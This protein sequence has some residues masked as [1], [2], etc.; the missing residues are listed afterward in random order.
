[1]KTATRAAMRAVVFE[2]FGGPEVLA[3]C[4][5][6]RPQPGPQELLVRVQAAALNRADTLQRAGVYAPPP[7]QVD[8]PGV[9]I[10]GEVAAWGSEV[11]GF[12]EGDR[13]FGITAGGGYAE[14]CAID[15]GMAIP[16]PEGWSWTV[17]AAVP[18]VFITADLTLFEMGHLRAG[19]TV[20]VHAAGSGVGT[21]CVQLARHAGA[22]VLA[23]CSAAKIARAEA[24]GAEAIDRS[25]DFA[26]EVLA[27]TGG[28]GVDV[29]EDCAGAAYLKRNLSLLRPGGRL[30]EIG[31]LSGW[32]TEIDLETVVLKR[33]QIKGTAFRPRPLAEKRAVTRRFR[34]TW[35]PL[36]VDG[37]LFPVID[38]VF[39]LEQVAEAHR[40][41]DANL[42]FGKI[43]LTVG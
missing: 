43:L 10:A 2:G 35:L 3:L 41:M 38:S 40:R 19:E 25:G 22:R 6:P 7:G 26:A 15:Q 11:T 27:K 14:Y 31:L 33:L 34:D 30:V 18:E 32:V 42:N 23:T 39:P 9:E 1:M 28:E 24:L 13:V 21:A 37:R 20:L 36:L 17:A 8:I 5:L 16:L 4:E 12:R 29:I